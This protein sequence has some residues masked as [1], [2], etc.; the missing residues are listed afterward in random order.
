M[1]SPT[2]SLIAKELG[3]S[4][5]AVSKFVARGMPTD[6]VQSARAWHR[7][8][9]RPR[10]SSNPARLY[11]AELAALDGLWPIARAAHAAGRLDVV[12]PALSAAL[13]AVPEEARHLVLIDFEVADELVA[14]VLQM[15]REN[16]DPA[17]DVPMTEADIDVMSRFWY[18]VLAE[19][20][21]A[22]DH[23]EQD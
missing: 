19:E 9:V 14:P 16:V 11:A 18:A 6:C 4:A 5:A 15:L 10:M 12:R 17:N 3:M 21:D 8:H 20:L 13:Q 1:K 7:A 23:L 22:F 2:Q